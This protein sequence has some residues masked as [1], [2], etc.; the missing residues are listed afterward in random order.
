MKFNRIFKSIAPTCLLFSIGFTSA[1]AQM[2]SYQKN[3]NLNVNHHFINNSNIEGKIF[4]SNNN[5]TVVGFMCDLNNQSEKLTYDAYI[6]QPYSV[7]KHGLNLEVNQN[8]AN[9]GYQ[10]VI[11][12]MHDNTLDSDLNKRMKILSENHPSKIACGEHHYFILQT[13]Q[14][15]QTIINTYWSKYKLPDALKIYIHSKAYGTEFGTI[16]GSGRYFISNPNK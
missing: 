4:Y 5:G 13:N 3:F 2:N 7:F 8:T 10:S 6:G 15:Q 16:T 14:K 1:N 12:L 11:N 9:I